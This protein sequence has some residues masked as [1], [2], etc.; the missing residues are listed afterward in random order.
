[1]YITQYSY[2]LCNTVHYTTH[3]PIYPSSVCHSY[4]SGSDNDAGAASKL[5]ENR[6]LTHKGLAMQNALTALE[7]EVDSIN[8]KDLDTVS[9]SEEDGA[10]ASTSGSKKPPSAKERR[11]AKKTAADDASRCA[12]GRKKQRRGKEKETEG[13]GEEKETNSATVCID[14]PHYAPPHSVSQCM[15]TIHILCNS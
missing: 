2:T 12:A 8:A 1:M 6:D 10:G 4:Q 14:A 9:A 13:E 5:Q 15:Y 3:P 7:E 11:E